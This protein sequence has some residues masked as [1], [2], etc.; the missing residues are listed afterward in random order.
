MA[1]GKTLNAANLETLGAARLAQ[2]LLEISA[3]DA[4]ARRRLRLALAGSAG[5]A[6]T[7]REVAKRLASL[8]AATSF[9]D[10][11]K[12]KPLLAELQA[13]HHA[14]R[15]F[16]APADPREAFELLWRLVGCAEPVLARCDDGDERL[17]GRFR[18]AARDLGPLAQRAGL[19]PDG[20][21]RRAFEVLRRNERDVWS[22]LVPILAPQL[23]AP[24]LGL[25]KGLVE[26]WQAEPVVVPPERERKVI[27]WSTGGKIYAD[28]LQAHHRKHVASSV[29]RQIAEALGDVD[30]YIAQF[31]AGARKAPRVAAE[32]ARRLLKTGRPQDALDA[33]EAATVRPD[34][35]PAEWEQARI[36]TLE[37]LGRPEEA[38]AYR[39]QRV[40]AAL[41]ATHLRAY[42][43]KLPDFED[44]EAEQRAM[45]HALG[46]GDVHRALHFLIEWPDLHRASQ[47]V[48][49][50]IRELDGG[51]YE[52]LGPAA[53]RL[54]VKHPL[55]A[56][57]L[58]R[59]MIDSTLAAFRAS[60]YGDAAR[61]LHECANLAARV[62]EFGDAP[63]HSAYEKA[64]RADHGREAAFWQ[65][66]AT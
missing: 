25:M 16:V 7:V 53:E 11:N 50:R 40:L 9:V 18:D 46:H 23:G 48:L 51:Q 47:L 42:L 52:L 2:L 34:G 19:E 12:V 29:L 1:T 5:P 33:L 39:W 22:D 62:A 35:M 56:T 41:D 43:A 31:D 27:G 55:A 38:Q 60:R 49:G 10:W 8:A 21:A 44:F 3:G 28:Q 66:V 26:S 24:G 13:L 63:D 59:A 61:H 65:G 17:V 30:S 15:D 20:L 57:L 32:I 45:E 6:A 14:I 58:R 54:E 36:A 64:L 37:T 4:A